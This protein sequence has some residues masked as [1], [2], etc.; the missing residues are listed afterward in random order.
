MSKDELFT[1]IQEYMK[2]PPVVIWGSGA[3]VAFGMPTMTELNSKLKTNFDYFDKNS[4]NLEE[5]L[6]KEKY[7]EKLPE[8]KKKYLG[9]CR[10]KR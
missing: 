9:Y 6:G 3:T 5:E 4:Q 7:I 10:R 8:I 1:L 2:N